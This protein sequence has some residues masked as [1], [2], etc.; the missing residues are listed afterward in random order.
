MPQRLGDRVADGHAA[1]RAS[2]TDPGRRSASGAGARAAPRRRAQRGPRRR[3]HR[4]PRSAAQPQDRAARPWS[5]RSPTRRPGPASRRGAMSN[6]TP[7]TA[8]HRRPLRAGEH[9][10]QWEVLAQPAH[11]R[12][13]ARLM[14]LSVRT[15]AGDDVASAR[16]RPAAGAPCRSRAARPGSAGWKRQPAGQPVRRRDGA[17]D[18]AAGPGSVAL[19]S[20]A[21]RA[22]RPRV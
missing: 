19:E 3:T 4:R 21:R 20:R 18:R 5:C 9:R 8:L 2:R 7:S 22:S 12:A 17:R 1:G 15:P 10:R 16:R 13:A 14:A 11:P 6:D